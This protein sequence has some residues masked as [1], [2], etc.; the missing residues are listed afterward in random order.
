VI[1]PE[2]LAQLRQRHRAEMVLVLVQLEQVCPGWWESLT[3]LAE[4]L[5][6]DRA[7]L[8]RSLRQLEDL[9][10]IRRCSISNR[11]GT[12]IWW[13]KRYLRDHPRP[14]TEPAWRLQCQQ[15]GAEIRVPIS[16]RRQWAADHGVPVS[17]L[18]AFLYGRQQTLRDRWRLIGSPLDC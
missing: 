17:T 16:S 12:W 7:T 18:C 13:V 14:G 15:T 6:T 4:Q 2:F 11:S 1:A 9:G 5:G 10:L 8:N 3:D